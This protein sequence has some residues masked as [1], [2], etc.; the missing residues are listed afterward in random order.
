MTP[1][2]CVFSNSLLQGKTGLFFV[3]LVPC[4]VVVSFSCFPLSIISFLISS[5]HL[6]LQENT[7]IFII[8]LLSPPSFPNYTGSESHMINQAPFLNT[9]LIGISS[10]DCVQ[11][12][13]LHG[14]VCCVVLCFFLLIHVHNNFHIFPERKRR[15]INNRN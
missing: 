13:S 5:Y 12:F 4:Y 7:I 8:L 9:L 2:L 1:I 15:K 6:Y 11:I 10:V 14:L 3:Y